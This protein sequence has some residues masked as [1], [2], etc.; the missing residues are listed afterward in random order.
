MIDGWLVVGYI[1]III[2]LSIIV[3]SVSAIW[4]SLIGAP[5]V[6][7]SIATVRKMLALAKVNQ[8]DTLVDLGSG[9]GRIIIMAAE[10]F[11]ASAF[12]VEADPLRVL[13]SRKVIRRR[14]LKDKV[15]VIW[16][17]FFTQSLVEASVVAIYQGHDI[18][19][20]L[21]T[22]LASELTPGTRVVSYSFPFDGWTPV[23]T[24]KNP[25]IYL[26]VI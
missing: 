21:K 4:P 16:G 19:N 9:D 20:Q 13:W 11:G 7:T 12:G 5:W 10:E 23:E 26:Y 6:P 22:K 3:F 24:T 17:N 14:G 15:K 25:N 8:N 1:V 2:L 18:N